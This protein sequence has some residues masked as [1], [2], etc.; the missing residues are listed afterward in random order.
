M[1]ERCLRGVPYIIAGNN[2][3]NTALPA[4][5][6]RCSS[7]VNSSNWAG[8]RTEFSSSLSRPAPRHLSSLSLALLLSLSPSL[9]LS[10]ALLSLLLPSSVCLS[11][12]C[13]RYSLRLILR[14]ACFRRLIPRVLRSNHYFSDRLL[15]VSFSP[16]WPPAI[17]LQCVILSTRRARALGSRRR[18]N[19]LVCACVRTC[20]AA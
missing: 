10:P 15:L 13:H 3:N 18:A 14:F 11:P 20:A 4:Q 2:N 7:C 19:V 17:H 16:P 8:W 6:A 9:P 12:F 5:E 1:Q